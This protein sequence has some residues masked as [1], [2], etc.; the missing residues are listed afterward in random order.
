MPSTNLR[1][2]L[3][4]MIWEPTDLDTTTY[5]RFDG[6]SFLAPV[7]VMECTPRPSDCCAEWPTTKKW[8]KGANTLRFAAATNSFNANV[9]AKTVEMTEATEAARTSESAWKSITYTNWLI[10]I[11]ASAIKCRH[12]QGPLL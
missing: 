7:A 4:G 3:G 10:H 8:N 5:F 1:E 11:S 2:K 12:T 9:K 6:A